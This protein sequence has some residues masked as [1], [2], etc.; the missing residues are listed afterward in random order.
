[1]E[2]PGVV[3]VTASPPTTSAAQRATPVP[4]TVTTSPPTSPSTTAQLD[5]AAIPIPR[6][7]ASLPARS[8]YTVGGDNVVVVVDCADLHDGQSFRGDVMLPGVSATEPDPAQ[9]LNAARAACADD[10]AKFVG[11]P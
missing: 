1:P 7:V 4:T 5:L 9:W 8:C 2:S 6:A 11:S 3:A 10:F